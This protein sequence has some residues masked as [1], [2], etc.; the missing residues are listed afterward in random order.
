MARSTSGRTAHEPEI[1]RE[2]EWDDVDAAQLVC[3]E[4]D[5]HLRR[6]EAHFRITLHP[7]GNRLRIIGPRSAVDSAAELLQ[8]LY[9]EAL[10]GQDVESTL[11]RR[12][13]PAAESRRAAASTP[14]DADA[15]DSAVLVSYRNKRIGPRTEAQ[16]A[17]VAAMDAND[18][19][20]GVGPA[21]TGKT[22][23]AVLKGVQ[24]LLAGQVNRMILT[25]PAVEAGERLGFLPGDLAEKVNPYLRPLY[26]ALHDMLPFDRVRGMLE[27]GVIEVAPLAF[28]RGRTLS[29]AFVILDEAQNTTP[30]QMKM[31]LTRIGD[32]SRVVVTGDATQTDLPRDRSSG[33]LHALRVLR[34][35]AGVAVLEF[36]PQDVVRHPVV[37]R[38]IDAYD[39]DDARQVKLPLK[40]QDPS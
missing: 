9:R 22:Y 2:L 35:V 8:V 16:A 19:T 1:I 37:Q 24:S 29:Q 34:G 15:D 5:G 26:D 13:R 6:I 21:G 11:L 23:L 10:R 33:L 39:A 18:V 4:R 36:T 40:V 7:R 30:E 28:M 25:R 14:I 27:T 12:L 31:F 17:Y 3:G 38:I 20:F 32:G